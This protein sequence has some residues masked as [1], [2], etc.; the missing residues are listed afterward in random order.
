MLDEFAGFIIEIGTYPLR[1]VANTVQYIFSEEFRSEKHEDWA[2]DS[3]LYIVGE[4]FF[5]VTFTFVTLC[6]T[7]A[8]VIGLLF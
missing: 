3:K 7:L 5:G 6:I 1:A 2:S 4:V 8:I